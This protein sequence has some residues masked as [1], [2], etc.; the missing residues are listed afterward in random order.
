[1]ADLASRVEPLLASFAEAHGRLVARLEGATDREAGTAPA[2]GGWTPAQ[3]GAH[4]GSFDLL[5]SRIV[6]GDL[7]HAQPAAVGFIERPWQDIKAAL[8]GPLVAPAILRPPADTS[9]RDA[10]SALA[11]G[12]AHVSAAFRSLDP[13]RAALT[14]T[15]PAVGT[16]SLVQLGDWLVAH[17]IRHNAQMKRALGR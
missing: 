13:R 14:F 1:M 10:L 6:T 11:T 9:R 17:T 16:L 3:I 8:T 4:V 12:G 7:P 15:Y 5:I 2:D